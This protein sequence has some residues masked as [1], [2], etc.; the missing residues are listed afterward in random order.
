M[1]RRE[2]SSF[3]KASHYSWHSLITDPHPP[4]NPLYPPPPIPP[5]IQLFKYKLWRERGEGQT[6]KSFYPEGR[7]SNH[8]VIHTHSHQI[9]HMYT[10]TQHTALTHTH[11]TALTHRDTH[12]HREGHVEGS[13]VNV[14]SLGLVGTYNIVWESVE[15]EHAGSGEWWRE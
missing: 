14:V 7:G 10:H 13:R 4:H 8:A 11:H 15:I 1:G 3:I 9:P 12:R 2:A 6:L 5:P